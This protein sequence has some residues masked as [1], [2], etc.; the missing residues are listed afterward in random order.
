LRTGSDVTRQSA[1][2]AAR[3]GAVTLELVIA[4]DLDTA[5]SIGESFPDQNFSIVDR[6]SFAVKQRRGVFR[7]ASFDEH[8]AI[9]R[10]GKNRRRAFEI[11]N[12]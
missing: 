12:W 2:D 8:F 10:F 5:F 4:A 11:F 3:T 1:S 9:Y 7:A 6:T